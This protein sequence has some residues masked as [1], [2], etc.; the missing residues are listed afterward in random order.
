MRLLCRTGIVCIL[1]SGLT[2]CAVSEAQSSAVPMPAQSQDGKSPTQKANPSPAYQVVRTGR[3]QLVKADAKQ[4]QKDLLE[5]VVDVHIPDVESPT[6]SDALRYV[7]RGT[8]YQLC[9]A[10]HAPQTYLYSRPLPAAHHQ[11]GPM[12]LRSA[13]Q[14]LAGDPWELEADGISRT[15]CYT[16]TF[17]ARIAS[18]HP[19]STESTDPNQELPR[20]ADHVIKA[21]DSDADEL[22]LAKDAKP[23]TSAGSPSAVSGKET[24]PPKEQGAHDNHGVDETS[25][26]TDDADADEGAKPTPETD[27]ADPKSQP[28]ELPET[29]MRTS[30]QVVAAVDQP[31]WKIDGDVMLDKGLRT[32][33]KKSGWQLVWKSRVNYRVSSSLEF[34]G[35][36]TEAVTDL[37]MLYS[38][39]EKPLY[40]DISKQQLIVISDDP[41]EL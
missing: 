3:Y 23:D 27:K 6:V 8:G 24:V 7:L 13:L 26:T 30:R 37:V 41:K 39:S 22:R 14:M 18:G 5:Q 19:S 33:M 10:N 40:A 35:T 11:I 20:D 34:S 1:A 2:A 31:L 17:G 21:G 38:Q 32:W 4:G 9:D 36:L 15:V 16:P 29:L 28:T 25:A 12:P